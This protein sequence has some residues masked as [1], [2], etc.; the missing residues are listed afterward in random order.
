MPAQPLWFHRL[1]DAIAIL[2]SAADAADWI[3]RRSVQ[4]LLGVSSTVAWRILKAA[5][6]SPGPGGALAIPRSHFL[7]AL[8][9][10]RASETVV[11]ESSR[12]R[13][14]AR[15]IEELATQW[16]SRQ[17]QVSPEIRR[18][19]ADQLAPGVSLEPGQLVFRFVTPEELVAQLGSI[20]FAL[21]RDW[22]QMR[23]RL[24]APPMS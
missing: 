21:Q 18:S 20:L 15:E 14:V 24:T 1:D 23:E 12:R 3:D 8:R 13:R 17:V 22:D 5:G 9:R 4:A 7:A 2:E 10:W 19:R 6:S 16:R 11:R